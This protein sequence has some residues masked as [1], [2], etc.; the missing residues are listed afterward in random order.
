MTSQPTNE[1]LEAE[2]QAR[3]Q[4]KS[5]ARRKKRI[6]VFGVMIAAALLIVVAVAVIALSMLRTGGQSLHQAATDLIA[7]GEAVSY[8]E[9][10]TI[11]YNGN[12]YVL[13]EDVVSIC[14]IGS[15]RYGYHERAG[16]SGEADAVMVLALDTKTGEATAIGIPRDSMVE[17]GE[18]VGDAFIGMDDM[19]L[20]LAYSYGDGEEKSCEYVT[21]IAQRVLYNMPISYY[22]SVDMDGVGPMA[23]A[24][25]GVPVTALE[26]IP[27]I[28]VREGDE[29]VLRGQNA[30]IYVQY[31]N[32]AALSSSI[33]RQARQEQFF[34]AYVTQ[35]ISTAKGDISVLLDLYDLAN[36][37]STTNLGVDEFAYLAICM[38]LNGMTSLDT[39]VLQGEMQEV[40][41][42]AAYY[43][44][45]DFVYQTI[46]DVYYT[47]VDAA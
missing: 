6:R 8:D 21:A 35:A 22:F 20:C 25:G 27:T 29:L 39:V 10:K 32:K 9:G 46:L 16:Q 11:E 47:P 30:L 34:K 43:L 15:G 4:E 36:A 19:Q 45:K 5:R 13:N 38:V 18:Y 40:D 26:S 42:Y 33:D 24:V 2:V 41:G 37:Y 17:V 3:K 7:S 44:D 23:N 1:S 14:V 12:T 31:R 28:G